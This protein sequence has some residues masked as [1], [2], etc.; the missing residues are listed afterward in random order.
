MNILTISLAVFLVSLSAQAQG[1]AAVASP[2]ASPA[3][4][5]PAVIAATQPG[6]DLTPLL[7]QLQ[8]AS[9]E[10]AQ[11]LSRLRIEKWKADA[12]QKQLAQHNAD[13]V[14]RNLTAA[15]PGLMEQVRQS[16]QSV[17]AA[18]KLYR[19][20]NALYDVLSSATESAGAFGTKSEFQSLG[21][22]LARLDELRRSCG[23]RLQEMAAASDAELR[24]WRARSVTATAPP[25][26]PRKIVVDD[27]EKPRKPVR[28]K[29]PPAQSNPEPA[30]GAAAPQT[31]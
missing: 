9:Q 23:E 18:F 15:L 4:T 30:A 5:S 26:P 22:D 25:P 28:K 24:G 10:I 13:S 2:A 27:E 6:P 14:N 20:V 12:G 19:N 8:T 1:A 16:P 21:S 3:T 7:G 29:K 17:A 31:K 11:D